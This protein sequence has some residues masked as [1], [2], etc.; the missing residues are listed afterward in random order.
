[1]LY[2]ICQFNNI[3]YYYVLGNKMAGLREI[4]AGNLKKKRQICGF[5]QAKL[6]EKVNVSTHHI[7]MIEIT[8]NFPTTD[9]IERIANALN[10]EI[11]ELF[12]EE[13]NSLNKEFERLREG[14]KSD[15]RQLYA[16]HF[17][18]TDAERSLTEHLWGNFGKNNH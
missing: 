1:M 11:Y 15:I 10:I 14:I 3:F 4:F 9:L 16:E 2:I 17:K 5:S 12:L 6:A 13:T 8:R 18:M 7:A